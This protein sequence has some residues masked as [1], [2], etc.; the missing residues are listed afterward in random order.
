M[1]HSIQH[2]RLDYIKDISIRP[3]SP[4][5]IDLDGC[6]I[7][8][9]PKHGIAKNHPSKRI[10]SKSLSLENINV[11][12][13]SLSKSKSEKSFSFESEVKCIKN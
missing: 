3:P 11:Q 7:L 13:P 6:G 1:T 2:K 8:L 9:C 12:K 10:L 5:H 4:P